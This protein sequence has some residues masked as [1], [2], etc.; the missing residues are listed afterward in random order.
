MA[1]PLDPKA[2]LMGADGAPAADV[3]KA[4]NMYGVFNF[5]QLEQLQDQVGRYCQQQAAAGAASSAYAGTEGN[6]PKRR[7]EEIG[8]SGLAVPGSSMGGKEAEYAMHAAGLPPYHSQHQQ[9]DDD[10]S[11]DEE[12]D[13]NDPN[14]GQALLPNGQPR[15]RHYR[16]PEKRREQNRRASQRARHRARQREEQVVMLQQQLQMMQSEMARMKVQL[17]DA[18]VEMRQEKWLAQIRASKR[19][20]ATAAK[21]SARASSFSHPPLRVER[22][23][24]YDQYDGVK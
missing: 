18:K 4:L 21:P 5:Q 24:R 10:V 16:D 3:V 1:A 19:L 11:G 7:R 20:N 12:D 13:P 2:V 6:L 8:P 15:P 23:T 14:K 22:E 9:Y 17:D